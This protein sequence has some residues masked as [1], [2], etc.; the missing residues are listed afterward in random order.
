MICMEYF[1]RQFFDWIEVWGLLIPIFFLIKSKN[2]DTYLKP[3]RIYVWG[4]FIINLIATV[5]WKRQK[6]GLGEL[7]EWLTTNN[8]LYNVHSIVRL[9]LFSW[10]FILLNQRFMHRIKIILPFI[11]IVFTIIHFGFYENFYTH[12]MPSSSLLAVEA[13]ILL[14]YC[15]QYYIYML[16]EDRTSSLKRQPGFW[17][18]LG[19]TFYVAASFFIFLF[20]TYLIEEDMNFA[21]GL[22][23]VVNVTYLF[24]CICIAITFYKG[25]DK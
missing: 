10:F 6:L 22:W 19:L 1:L 8:Y 12:E 11:F 23:D 9:L 17:I 24:L 5:I 3:I 13:A 21:I 15:L 2:K 20:Y 4:A 18:V 7:P 25:N 16:L 14:F